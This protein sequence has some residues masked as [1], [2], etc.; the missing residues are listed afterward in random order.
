MFYSA[1]GTRKLQLLDLSSGNVYTRSVIGQGANEMPSYSFVNTYLPS[2][3]RFA[4]YRRGKIYEINL[5]SLRSD[6]VTTHSLVYELPLRNDELLLR[7]IETKESFYGTGILPE[8]RIWHYDKHTGQVNFCGEYPHHESLDALDARYKGAVFTA[9]L[10][11]CD[12]QHLVTSCFGLLD[13]YEVT[14]NKEL[15]LKKKRH[16]FFPKFTPHYEIGSPAI[17]FSKD[18]LYGFSEMVSDST[19]VYLLYSGK[20]IRKHGEDAYNCNELLVYDWE[21]NPVSRY[22]V[23]KSLRE[24]A[25]H[26]DI[27]Y[28]LSREKEAIVYL[29]KLPG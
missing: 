10:M 11:C 21:G 1:Q 4:D 7:Y 29:Y 5:D 2:S 16:Y 14:P 9:T 27:V 24:M 18:E 26:G 17:A 3:Y 8:G 23:Q 15:Q 6:S 12:D 28:G 13:F 19:H 20:N 25:I 22:H